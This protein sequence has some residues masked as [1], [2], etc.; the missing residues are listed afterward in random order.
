MRPG[1]IVRSWLIHSFSRETIL[2]SETPSICLDWSQWLHFAD[3]CIERAVSTGSYKS[4]LINAQASRCL[5]SIGCMF[6]LSHKCL[7]SVI[8]RRWWPAVPPRSQELDLR[9][10]AWIR[11][12]RDWSS[13]SNHVILSRWWWDFFVQK[14][15]SCLQRHHPWLEMTVISLEKGNG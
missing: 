7:W 15:E 6:L 1:D 3:P 8:M 13:L 9:K 11:K 2:G 10:M 4:S 12:S 5:G 14:V